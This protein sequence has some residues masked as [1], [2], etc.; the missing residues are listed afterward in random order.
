VIQSNFLPGGSYLSHT[1]ARSMCRQR[2]APDTHVTLLTCMSMCASITKQSSQHAH[3]EISKHE[4]TNEHFLRSVTH[5]NTI[6]CRDIC[7]VI[8]KKV[9]LPRKIEDGSYGSKHRGFECHLQTEKASKAPLFPLLSHQCSV[10]RAKRTGAT[11]KH[12]SSLHTS[13]LLSPSDSFTLSPSLCTCPFNAANWTG[14]V[15]TTYMLTH[16][17]IHFIHACTRSNSQ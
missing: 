7:R 3:A 12:Q 11:L 17:R 5:S 8:C 13:V 1:V 4:F 14:T 16:S 2:R 10:V 9:C 6:A 15:D